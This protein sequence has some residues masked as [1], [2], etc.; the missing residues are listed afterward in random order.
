MKL[1]KT[2]METN[3]HQQL[4]I[5]TFDFLDGLCINHKVADQQR[6]ELAERCWQSMSEESQSAYLAANPKIG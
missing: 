5:D 1:I 2:W 4:L 3:S 6:F